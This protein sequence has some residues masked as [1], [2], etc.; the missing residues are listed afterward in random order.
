MSVVR[1]AANPM[2]KA[3]AGLVALQR[4]PLVYCVEACDQSEPVS[5]LSLPARTELKAEKAPGL[6]GGV[7]VIKGSAEATPSAEWKGKLYQPA[8]AK[9][10][11]ALT[12]I[13]YYAWD[14]RQAGE[15][16]VWLPV[17]P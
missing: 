7:M 16:E 12:A 6:L 4:G 9:R 17:G 5:S 1:V 15:M 11:A 3:D 2:V 8:P 13:P 10:R 14:N